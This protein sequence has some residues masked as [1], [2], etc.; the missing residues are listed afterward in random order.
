MNKNKKISLTIA[1][2]MIISILLP[3][4]KFGVFSV[5]LLDAVKEGNPET[6]G[7]IVLIIA[8]GVLTFMDKHLFARICSVLI[9]VACLYG[10]FKM[11]DAQSGLSQLNVDVNVFSL[12]GIGAYLLLLGSI[13]GVIFSKPKSE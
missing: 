10:A 11:A 5:S 2:A 7:L 12:L 4:F 6:I 3:F 9:L 8:F 13:A 1:V